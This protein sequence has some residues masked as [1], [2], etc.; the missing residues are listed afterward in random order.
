MEF[1]LD[2]GQVRIAHQPP[3]RIGTG[4]TSVYTNGPEVR[5]IAC[6]RV[7]FVVIKHSKILATRGQFRAILQARWAGEDFSSKR[8]P[9]GDMVT[10]GDPVHAPNTREFGFSVLDS[11]LFPRGRMFGFA[12]GS[13]RSWVT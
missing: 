3:V 8:T 10:E 4:S 2:F 9:G 12:F 6:R 13:V 5:V 11:W 7:G 1:P